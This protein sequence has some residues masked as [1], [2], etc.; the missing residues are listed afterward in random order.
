MVTGDCGGQPLGD[1]LHNILADVKPARSIY[2]N[3]PLFSDWLLYLGCTQYG[4]PGVCLNLRFK[5]CE[6]TFTLTNFKTDSS[7]WSDI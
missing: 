3:E 6:N 7:V 1:V 5:D 4:S 2:I